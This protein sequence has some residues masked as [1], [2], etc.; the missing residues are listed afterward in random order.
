[1]ILI[2]VMLQYVQNTIDMHVIA[3]EEGTQWCDKKYHV[4]N[5]SP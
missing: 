1:M 5:D 4:G 2:F 3:L